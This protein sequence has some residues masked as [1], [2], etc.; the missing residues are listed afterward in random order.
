MTQPRYIIYAVVVL[1][2]IITGVFIF[3]PVVKKVVAQKLNT[4]NLFLL[5]PHNVVM[6]M[7][8]K[9]A[10]LQSINL[11]ISAYKATCSWSSVAFSGMFFDFHRHEEKRRPTK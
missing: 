7:S 4:L 5:V 3:R 2:T 9:T 1:V 10:K 6:K 8:V 11:T